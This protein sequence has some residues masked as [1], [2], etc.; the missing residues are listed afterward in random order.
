MSKTLK[1]K[2]L[3]E[4]IRAAKEIIK[5]KKNEILSCQSMIAVLESVKIKR[6]PKERAIEEEETW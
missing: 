4:Q 5:F 6:K 2:I 3:N 1:I